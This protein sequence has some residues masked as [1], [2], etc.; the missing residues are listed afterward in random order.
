MKKFKSMKR[1]HSPELI[2]P[3]LNSKN[4]IVNATF[5][6]GNSIISP[7]DHLS[8]KNYKRQRLIEDFEDLSIDKCSA[9]NKSHK[10][11]KKSLNSITG[12]T[13]S[14]LLSSKATSNP[15]FVIN[16]AVLETLKN[17]LLN[18]NEISINNDENR[19]GIL[20][21]Y[22]TD[23]QQFIEKF[24]SELIGLTMQLVKWYC[25]ASVIYQI[26]SK[27][28]QK[29]YNVHNIA[30]SWFTN[31][32]GGIVK[33]INSDSKISEIRQDE[34]NTFYDNDSIIDLEN[35]DDIDMED[36]SDIDML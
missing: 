33:N 18:N 22:D 27:W 35:N 9:N 30:K 11:F 32:I 34:G 1:P 15:S 8:I 12:G 31:N 24:R 14:A 20:S 28:Y 3:Y 13:S 26:W 16:E 29:K 5:D 25:M 36:A 6:G 19:K 2:K 21:L 7:Y 4:D 10:I 17:K 23:R